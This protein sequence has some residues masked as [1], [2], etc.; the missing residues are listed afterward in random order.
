MLALR[1]LLHEDLLE[2]YMCIAQLRSTEQTDRV[3][4]FLVSHA[5]TIKVLLCLKRCGLFTRI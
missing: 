1:D 4:L 3:G 5:N 2:D